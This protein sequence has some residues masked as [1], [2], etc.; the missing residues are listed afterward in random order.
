M[1]DN[2]STYFGQYYP[3]CSICRKTAEIGIS[4]RLHGSTGLKY[5]EFRIECSAC[6]S[7]VIFT[8]AYAGNELMD[9]NNITKSVLIKTLSEY[10]SVLEQCG[11]RLPIG[12]SDGW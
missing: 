9:L 10:R 12:H 4:T 6:K 2:F 11:I 7:S 5:P 8:R 3:V 1:K